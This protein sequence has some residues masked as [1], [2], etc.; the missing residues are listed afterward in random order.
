MPDRVFRRLGL[1]VVAVVG[2][3][4]LS[5][6]TASAASG[7][8]ASGITLQVNAQAGKDN[9][10]GVTLV[11]STFTVIDTGDTVT[12]G[13]G[14]VAVDPNTVRCS[15]A[16]I[17]RVVVN[18]G[19]GDDA[20]SSQVPFDT[21]VSGGPGR[22]RISTSVGDDT[23]D[24]GPED[25]SLS[26]GAGGDTLRGQAGNDRLLAAEGVD[27]LDGGLGADELGGGPD[28]DIVTYENRTANVNV[29]LDGVADDG[30][31]GEGDN[32]GADIEEIFG[33]AGHDVLT[34]TDDPN[35]QNRL[36]GG[37]G[38]DTLTG[39]AGVDRMFGNDGQ[40]TFLGGEGNDDFDGDAG[41]DVFN[42]GNGTDEVLYTERT[43][44]VTAKIDNVAKDG[45]PNENDDI[46]TD[47]EDISGGAGIDLLVG[48][49]VR[50]RLDGGNGDDTLLG[51]GDDDV[52]FGSNGGDRLHGGAGNDDL[53]GNSGDDTLNG[54]A[55]EDSL[56]GGS[57]N[58]VLAGGTGTFGSGND[59]PDFLVGGPD[60]DTADYLDHGGLGVT[61]TID[62]VDNDGA[63][64][65]KDHVFTDVENISGTVAKDVLTGNDQ[66]DNSLFG[67]PGDDT[68]SGLGG[69]DHLDCFTGIDFAN[70]GAGTDTQ[71]GCESTVGIP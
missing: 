71:S 29:D 20:V 28:R 49:S 5:P 17:S 26:A 34:G 9:R 18:A 62:G 58:D 14:C 51:E 38:N 7:V 25:D 60:T 23:L 16:G 42:G 50:N 69:N 56:F 13:T 36:V 22:D 47:V 6:G 46:R 59:G 27:T 31:S 12:P 37:P 70:G 61:V 41:A 39:L 63:P 10:I 35:V 64:G 65:E 45:E 44:G 53:N 32:A 11:N 43:V 40:D 15:A 52:L 54:G 1:P 30:E 4:L 68:L 21:T 8:T 3:V 66:T 57:G 19:D 48:S 24:G 55:N 67:G 33:G 2:A